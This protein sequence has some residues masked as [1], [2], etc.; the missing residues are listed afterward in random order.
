VFFENRE[1]LLEPVALPS[2]I[3]LGKDHFS[4]RQSLCRVWRSAKFARQNLTR[5]EGLPSAFLG[6]LDKKL[7][8]ILP[9]A[10]LNT[11]TKFFCRYTVCR[12]RKF[13]RVH[14]STLGNFFYFFPVN[15]AECMAEHSVN[16]FLF[17]P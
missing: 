17:F 7:P 1:P 13:C 16:L 12:Q 15:F 14:G 10:S 5:E 8:I 3:T 6:A 9:S 11:Q 2:V 4:T